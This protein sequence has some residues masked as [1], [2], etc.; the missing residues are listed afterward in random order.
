MFMAGTDG[1][2]QADLFTYNEQT[3]V[4]TVDFTC[5][6]AKAVQSNRKPNF[7]YSSTRSLTVLHS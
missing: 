4:I 5:A 3:R 6:F 1:L 2:F 7:C